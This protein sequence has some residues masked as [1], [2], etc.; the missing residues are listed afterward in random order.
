MGNIAATVNTELPKSSRQFGT[1]SLFLN[2]KGQAWS[3]NVSFP[4][5]P[6]RYH[7]FENSVLKM[8]FSLAWRPLFIQLKH[9]WPHPMEW[10]KV[11]LSG[12]RVYY[13]GLGYGDLASL[14]DQYYVPFIFSE[15]GILSFLDSNE[16]EVVKA[17][18]KIIDDNEPHFL[19][20]SDMTP[21]SIKSL[22]DE[23]KKCWHKW[24]Y[25]Y[26]YDLSRL[27]QCQVNV[28]PPDS[29]IC[30]YDV[31]PVIIS[32]GCLYNCGFCKA[33]DGT[34]YALRTHAQI[35]TQT[36]TLLQRLQ[37]EIVTFKGTF[38][39]NQDGLC[40]PEETIFYAVEMVKEQLPTVKNCFLF[41][42]VESL[43]SKSEKFFEILTQKGLDFYIN[44]GIESLDKSVLEL[45]KKPLAEN[46]IHK[47]WERIN[48]LNKVFPRVEISV[49]ILA[50]TRLPKS[51]WNILVKHLNDES[52]CSRGPI[53]LSPYNEK[54]GRDF[55]QIAKNI[56]KETSRP[57]RIYNFVPL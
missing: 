57:V 46:M 16:Y 30:D 18:N 54:L 4:H 22:F 19:T 50:N 36:Q 21:P 56:K 12:K 2:R 3:G 15:T 28:L 38:L 37:N 23:I 13:A 1:I 44:I 20:S 47:A 48:H 8:D 45:I 14:F 26:K 27:L 17:A 7:H 11:T 31:F 34:E 5:R 49:N 42:S 51:H 10:L 39:G 9:N 43:M 55:F 35:K 6:I 52:S 40:A 24:Q 33:K 41:G 32:T 29:M 25:F 53:Y